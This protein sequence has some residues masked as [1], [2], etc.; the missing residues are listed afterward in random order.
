MAHGRT[1][2]RLPVRELRAD[3]VSVSTVSPNGILV[4]YVVPR[5]GT[6]ALASSNA[7]GLRPPQIHG[8][9]EVCTGELPG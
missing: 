9:V 4:L 1:T 5:S 6:A 3:A 7:P 2:P 8:D